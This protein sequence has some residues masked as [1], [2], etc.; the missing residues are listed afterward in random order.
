MTNNENDNKSIE[1]T[2]I[3]S[4][5]NI[6][7][8]VSSN[9]AETT[10]SIQEEI[11]ETWNGNDLD[12]EERTPR[13]IL[14]SRIQLIT[15]AITIVYF[16]KDI[17]A[18]FTGN[19]DLINLI[20]LVIKLEVCGVIVEFILKTIVFAY[21]KVTGTTKYNRPKGEKISKKRIA[22]YIIL[23]LFIVGYL[24]IPQNYEANLTG[25]YYTE[26]G[27]EQYVCVHI[28]FE[29]TSSKPIKFNDCM[30]IELYQN[31]VQLNHVREISHG[32]KFYDLPVLNRN[33]EIGK[34]ESID[35]FLLY[36]TRNVDMPIEMSIEK[37]SDLLGLDTHE[38]TINW[39][40]I[41]VIQ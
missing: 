3:A 20:V 28:L 15:F 41:E 38:L 17:W 21:F 29:N 23:V 34:E 24:N 18:L 22:L 32:N 7:E 5:E 2:K 26:Y 6:N 12:E 27:N 30:A 8:N 40:D 36:E 10:K 31:D 25:V 19:F 39:N 14:L 16:I 11:K 33:T 35:V 1:N 9:E 13:N 4:N 37:I